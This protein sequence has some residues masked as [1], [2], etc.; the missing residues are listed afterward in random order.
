M[1]ASSAATLE[2][3]P[4]PGVVR[5]FAQHA[6]TPLHRNGYAL[7]AATFATSALGAL[8]W[9]IAAHEYSS[10]DVG[11]NASLI[12][13]MMFITNL[14]S[15]NFTDVL[16]RFVPVSRGP[17]AKRLVLVSYGIAVALG[18]ISATV[19]IVGAKIW[20]P[21]L[22]DLLHGPALG[23]VY[24]GATM[25]W[26]V[27][28]L[29]DAVLIGL[30]RATYVLVE[31]TA[32]GIVKIAMLIP[33]AA[34]LPRTGIFLS[35]TIPL[36]L[37]VVALNLVIFIG[38]LPRHAE[39]PRSVAEPA[40]RREIGRFLAADYVA[41]LAWTA[42]IAGMPVIA[43][44]VEGPSESAYVYLAWTI[45]Y[46]LYLVSR[47]LG[48]SLTTEGALD[49]ASLGAHARA[50]LVSAVR[51]VVP[52]A[53]VL[54]LASPIVL[55][56]FGSEYSDSGSDLLRLLALSAIPAI[57]P[58]IYVSA[59]RVQRRL[60]AMVIVTLASTV[61]AL[62]LSPFL[63]EAYGI[64]GVGMAWLV[65][66]AAVAL[67]LLPSMLWGSRWHGAG[68]ESDELPP[69]VNR[70]VE[71]VLVSGR[72]RARTVPDGDVAAEPPVAAA[73]VF[74]AMPVPSP[75][76][77]IEFA[78]PELDDPE[79]EAPE[80]DADPEAAQDPT[81][82]TVEA[83]IDAPVAVAGVELDND[84]GEL[85]EPVAEPRPSRLWWWTG[86]AVVVAAVLW[87]VALV[88]M[89]GDPVGKFGLVSGL[90]V[91][92]FVA[93]GVVVVGIAL[94]LRQDRHWWPIV[95]AVGVL[96]VVLHATTALV[97]PELPY[98][99]AWRHVGV[100]D[101]LSR[102]HVFVPQ[103]P[104]LPI[105][106]SWPGFFAAAT[107]LSES[108]SM[109][110]RS[111]AAWAPPVFEVL[112]AVAL[113]AVL[114][115]LTADRR[116]IGLG[117][118]IFVAANWIGQDYF[119]PQALAFL[120]YLVLLAIVLRWFR[121]VPQGEFVP[122]RLPA[123]Q[124]RTVSWLLVVV[125][126]ALVTSHPL[127]PIIASL[128]LLGML[129]FR[130]LDRRWPAILL[131]VLTLAWLLTGARNYV[132][133]NLSG[134]LSGF[135]KLGSNVGSNLAD[136]NRL[137][138][139]QQTVSNMGRLVVVLVALLAVGGI[140]RVTRRRRFELVPVLL[141]VAPGLTLAGGGYGGE[142]VFRVYLF[143]LPFA[144][145]LAA[146]VFFPDREVGERWRTTIAIT[147]VVGVLLTGFL[148][149]YFGKDDWA[150]FTPREVR[151]AE[152]VFAAAPPGA[153][154]VTGTPS[155]PAEFRNAERFTYVS[156]ASEPAGS[157]RGVL[158]HPVR[159]LG[160]WLTDT[161]FSRAYL[162]ITRSQIAEADETGVLPRG[163]LR[164][165]RDAI[166]ESDRFKVL[167]DNPDALVVTGRAVE[168]GGAP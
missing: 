138:S 96:V 161:S 164:R 143:A 50:T 20:S 2:P 39:L 108:A 153:L 118:V 114:G 94:G 103:T 116:R 13:T 80:V 77:M 146:G 104:V 140:I 59:A 71:L 135:G 144:A 38:L 64:V 151:A 111:F 159:E 63:L 52:L 9:A 122:P 51:I 31:N 16:N 157:V 67:V 69:P 148:F 97:Y 10:R 165:V 46:T 55:Q 26:V 101:L 79:L 14:A 53:I 85:T 60:T 35:W 105:Y 54:A 163:A 152:R 124:R 76:G 74:D 90:P 106:Q 32:F 93:L 155:Y 18:G 87:V 126:V 150:R 121:R 33:M 147:G 160:L 44:R 127:T 162:I 137:S 130:Q 29:Q 123:P 134:L 8:Y 21:W 120:L 132:S 57:V 102:G 1:T 24:V 129:V 47:N 11:L 136:V 167:V 65:V 5:R 78:M 17:G 7:V 37:V 107:A 61:P 110:S 49:P 72:F 117:V 6:R 58:L 119:A 139:A 99:W 12:S 3:A 30:R 141:V 88:T 154:V 82:E 34:L 70:P 36:L 84:A 15:L 115:A 145:Y 113:A 73:P 43:L 68:V 25:L 83:L 4:E 48:M 19:F 128:G 45:A 86:A 98:A 133:E 166:V 158:A 100:V 42:A 81:E 95:A 23:A 156:L 92:Y 125:M 142:G 56:V 75:L 40:G 89:G 109:S 149:A 22:N 66:Q 62:V 112:G 27:F 91:T 168:P 131:P 28:V 41:M